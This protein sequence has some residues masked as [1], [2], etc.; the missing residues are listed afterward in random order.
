MLEEV[1]DGVWAH[2]SRLL[3]NNSVVVRGDQ[4]V[5]L[6]DPGV[7]RDELADLASSL[8][9]P[10]VAGF[11]THPD[12]DH[13]LWHPA[14]G[15]VPR[16]GTERCAAEMRS[17]LATAD[18]KERVA[19]VTPPEIVDEVPYDDSFGRITGLPSGAMTLPWRGPE[20][21]ILEHQAHAAGHAALLIEEFGVLIAGD[22]LSDVLV[23]MLDYGATDPIGDYLAALDLLESAADERV[24]VIPGHGSGGRDLRARVDLDRAYV[25]TLRDGGEF[26]DPRIGPAAKP[27]WEWVADVHAGLV[28]RFRL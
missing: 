10:V 23:P 20:V 4:G 14:F 26:D 5:L 28:S 25:T 15:E 6:I 17:L 24:I 22:M 12:W 16:Y 27:G 7:T 19:E 1:T 8:P 18:W 11:A 9:L 2:Q 21:S 13:V 3:E